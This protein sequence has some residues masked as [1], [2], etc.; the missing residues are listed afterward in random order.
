MRRFALADRLLAMLFN[1]GGD[2]ILKDQT[3]VEFFYKDRGAK[4]VKVEVY[5]MILRLVQD[6]AQDFEFPYFHFEFL[7]PGFSHSPLYSLHSRMQ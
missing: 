6:Q 5:L 7:H 3:L 4:S 1:D 2:D